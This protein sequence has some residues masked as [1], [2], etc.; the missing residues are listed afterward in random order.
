MPERP[1]WFREFVWE[2]IMNNETYSYEDLVHLGEDLVLQLV[3]DSATDLGLTIYSLFHFVNINGVMLDIIYDPPFGIIP[4][5]Y[6]FNNI[7]K[8]CGWFFQPPIYFEDTFVDTTMFPLYNMQTMHYVSFINYMNLYLLKV[9][10]NVLRVVSIVLADTAQF[11][12]FTDSWYFLDG[13]KDGEVND[14]IPIEADMNEWFGIDNAFHFERWQWYDIGIDILVPSFSVLI[15]PNCFI[16][17]IQGIAYYILQFVISCIEGSYLERDNYFLWGAWTLQYFLGTKLFILC[18]LYF[19]YFLISQSYLLIMKYIDYWLEYIYLRFLEKRLYR[20]KLY[21][22]L[23]YSWNDT[24]RHQRKFLSYALYAINSQIETDLYRFHIRKY[25]GEVLEFGFIWQFVRFWCAQFPY[26]LWVWQLRWS[27]IVSSYVG[28]IY[29]MFLWMG[30]IF[31]I[32]LFFAMLVRYA[33]IFNILH[34]SIYLFYYAIYW[35]KEEVIQAVYYDFWAS[36]VKIDNWIAM[37]TFQ[38]SHYAFFQWFTRYFK[39][40][41]ITYYD[42]ETFE[43]HPPTHATW[44]NDIFSFFKFRKSFPLLNFTITKI[45]FLKTFIWMI[46]NICLLIPLIWLSSYIFNQ[47]KLKCEQ[48]DTYLNLNYINYQIK[49]WFLNFTLSIELK[50]KL[51]SIILLILFYYLFKWILLFILILFFIHLAIYSIHQITKDLIWCTPKYTCWLVGF[52]FY[53][54]YYIVRFFLYTCLYLLLSL[55]LRPSFKFLILLLILLTFNFKLFYLSADFY[56]YYVY[57]PICACGDT[58]LKY[59]FLFCDWYFNSHMLTWRTYQPS[60]IL[61]QSFITHDAFSSTFLQWN[62]FVK[63]AIRYTHGTDPDD[64]KLQEDYIPRI[65]ESQIFTLI[66]LEHFTLLDPNAKWFRL[67]FTRWRT[68]RWMLLRYAVYELLKAFIRFHTVYNYYFDSIHWFY[69]RPIF[70]WKIYWWLY[71]SWQMI[72]FILIDI[73]WHVFTV[74]WCYIMPLLFGDYLCRIWFIKIYP[75]I[76]IIKSIWWK[77]WSLYYIRT[78]TISFLKLTWSVI[79]VF[80]F[81]IVG[82]VEMLYTFYYSSWEA[83]YV[84]NISSQWIRFHTIF[85]ICT[86]IMWKALLYLFSDLMY[87]FLKRLPIINEYL[88]QQIH[89]GRFEGPSWEWRHKFRILRF[90]GLLFFNT[91]FRTQFD[92]LNSYSRV[93]YHLFYDDFHSH[94]SHYNVRR[95]LHRARRWYRHYRYTERI[96]SSSTLIEWFVD[97]GYM[98]FYRVR[99]FSRPMTNKV[100]LHALVFGR[101]FRKHVL[102]F[103]FVCCICHFW[104]L[105]WIFSP[106][107]SRNPSSAGLYHPQYLWT[108]FREKGKTNPD[109]WLDQHFTIDVLDSMT[110][111]F[112]TLEQILESK[113]NIN[114]AEYQRRND[115][116]ALFGYSE[117]GKEHA[118]YNYRGQKAIHLIREFTKLSKWIA[119]IRWFKKC[120]KDDILN[121]LKTKDE[122]YLLRK[123][124]DKKAQQIAELKEIILAEMHNES[125][126]NVNK[127][128]VWNFERAVN[129]DYG[130]FVMDDGMSKFYNLYRTWYEKL[131]LLIARG[132][133]RDPYLNQIVWLIDEE[134]HFSL[135]HS[136]QELHIQSYKLTEQIWDFSYN[137]SKVLGIPFPDWAWYKDHV[138]PTIFESNREIF[139]QTLFTP[140]EEE[141]IFD[142]S[143][144]IVLWFPVLLLLQILR[145]N[146]SFRGWWVNHA[147]RLDIA[148]LFKIYFVNNFPIWQTF[149]QNFPYG[150]WAHASHIRYYGANAYADEWGL[151]YEYF[152]WPLYDPLH[153]YALA[154]ERSSTVWMPSWPDFPCFQPKRAESRYFYT[155]PA[156][157]HAFVQF[158]TLCWMWIKSFLLAFFDFIFFTAPNPILTVQ[159]YH[160][161]WIKIIAIL[162]LLLIGLNKRP[163]IKD[164]TI[165][166]NMDV[167]AYVKRYAKINA[168]RWNSYFSK[169]IWF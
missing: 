53:S 50:V 64:V 79:L 134:E 41:Q 94:M 155:P 58:F 138:T 154:N 166:L 88:W 26:K 37:Y 97:A 160:F 54:I 113:I 24:V 28:R 15:N 87:Y 153:N 2:K 167:I 135:D 86:H 133:R 118:Q 122:L 141:F 71:I 99:R 114:Y 20:L 6:F 106:I 32:K 85:F 23:S 19:L 142:G 144:V 139:G 40:N 5:Y 11:Y 21:R 95:Y 36:F 68:T 143:F 7:D 73:A 56:Y 112:T 43:N 131:A 76:A 115:M 27:V 57:Y 70:G 111:K 17:Y 124:L 38:D 29:F 121:D 83:I 60:S 89:V 44:F 107:I 12:M 8:G 90:K 119:T 96:S 75:Y 84:Y 126:L 127:R 91:Y 137:F 33:H 117:A 140:E 13:I 93:D 34:Y 128:A 116:E 25:L 104:F 148:F 16:I 82:T 92:L 146:Y 42:V 30:L 10:A 129:F 63:D 78:I 169:Q 77:S 81:I 80:F 157:F 18:N 165:N 125:Y 109:F 1:Y 49:L 46:V 4:D 31:F 9:P 162:I 150:G 159:Y 120:Y 163:L 39:P 65:E 51:T 130:S 101:Y 72:R 47:L 151:V 3:C 168:I 108:L 74:T 136:W 55:I 69:K 145:Y 103:I 158:L 132:Y 67:W 59:V 35:I 123:R 156:F 52:P 22:L 102:F 105:Y 61:T 62:E 48:F 152:Y 147:E 66:G 110:D 164:H 45:N 100:T 161:K 98:D 14:E 149:I